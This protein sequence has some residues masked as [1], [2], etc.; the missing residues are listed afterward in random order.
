MD[1]LTWHQQRDA[2]LWRV[3]GH[4][5]GERYAP[6]VTWWC[7][8]RV[9]APRTHV[10]LQYL[11][12]GRAVLRKAGVEHEIHAG[13]LFLF[14]YAD[15]SAYGRPPD[16]PDWPGHDETLIT[17]HLSLSGAGLREH[18]DLLRARHG[19]VLPLSPKSPL[20]AAMRELAGMAL[21]TGSAPLL[22]R[23]ATLVAT[24]TA[25]IESVGGA[26]RSPVERAIEGILAE[27]FADHNLKAIAERCGCSREH[28][29]RQFQAQIGIPPGVWLRDR[30][31]AHALALLRDTDL[32]LAVIA[33]RCGAASAHR[34]ARWMRTTHG[35]PPLALR[36]R[37]R[38]ENQTG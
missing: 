26:D 32:P 30:R 20:L 21:P 15:D 19:S 14:A 23:I 13:D 28:L 8:N 24:L 9:R 4:M 29:G 35:L 1:A 11:R 2:V 37:M 38:R 33:E 12:A 22:A 17:D 36:R 5:F 16:R 31:S 27:P 25:T 18:W 6:R 7:D 3:Q 10:T 34:L